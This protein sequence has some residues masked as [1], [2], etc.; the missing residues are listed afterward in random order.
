MTIEVPQIH[1]D[2]VKWRDDHEKN[3][4]DTG[5]LLNDEEAVSERGTDSIFKEYLERKNEIGTDFD[6][7]EGKDPKNDAEYA[8]QLGK[9]AQGD[10]SV[11]DRDGNGTVSRSEYMAYELKDLKGDDEELKDLSATYAYLMFDIIDQAMGNSNANDK[12]E[13]EEFESFYRNLDRFN[14]E[15]FE[16]EDGVLN[17]D[18]CSSFVAYL[19]DNKIS[20][21]TFNAT[22]ELIKEII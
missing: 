7:M 2:M 6:F 4:I 3:V 19:V 13:K 16:D 17:I 21:D 12:I 11:Y 8:E 9:L 18:A 5:R 1:N 22:Y 20:R 15:G 10:I 14:G